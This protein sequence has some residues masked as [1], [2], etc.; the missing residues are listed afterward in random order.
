MTVVSFPFR[1]VPFYI[2]IQLESCIYHLKRQ[3]YTVCEVTMKYFHILKVNGCAEKNQ[4]K[5]P[6]KM[7]DKLEK[8]IG[9]LRLLQLLSQTE[10]GV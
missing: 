6:G 4:K 3:E 10:M 7:F 5:V 8:F 9:V 1:I 2:G